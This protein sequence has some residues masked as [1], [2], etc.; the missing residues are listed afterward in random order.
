MDCG[1]QAPK[2]SLLPPVVLDAAAFNAAAARVASRDA[3][4]PVRSAV[5]SAA[6]V[7]AVGRG[8]AFAPVFGCDMTLLRRLCQR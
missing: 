8:M 3:A 7:A 2:P 6:D 1:V 5:R 4:L